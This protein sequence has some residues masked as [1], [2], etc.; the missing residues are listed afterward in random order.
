MRNSPLMIS[1]SKGHCQLK[2]KLYRVVVWTM[3]MH[4]GIEIDT[5]GHPG[6]KKLPVTELSFEI[7]EHLECSL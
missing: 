2:P 5:M 1:S 4:D 3:S 6:R 7:L